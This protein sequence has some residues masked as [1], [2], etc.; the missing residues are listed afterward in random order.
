MLELLAAE[1]LDKVTPAYYDKTLI[2]KYFRDDESAAMLDIIFS[3]R[4]YDLGWYYKLGLY[5]D[6]ILYLVY[7]TDTDFASRYA[8]Y[9]SKALED[10]ARINDTFSQTLQK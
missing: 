3:N 9:E 4:V 2:G 7:Q 10:V 6:E 1:S 8:K 5:N